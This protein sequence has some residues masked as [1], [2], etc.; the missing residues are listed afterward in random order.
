MTTTLKRHRTSGNVDKVT[1]TPD[2]ILFKEIP[3]IF[4]MEK[5][6]LGSILSV[7]L[8]MKGVRAG[9]L[10]LSFKSQDIIEAFFANNQRMHPVNYRIYPERPPFQNMFKIFI[11]TNN[12]PDDL[13]TP[14]GNSNHIALGRFLGYLCPR[15]LN[16]PAAD[17]K[18][19]TNY[20]INLYMDS[21]EKGKTQKTQKLNKTKKASTNSKISKYIIYNFV[22]INDDTNTVEIQ[23]QLS[24]NCTK[25]NKYCRPKFPN[26]LPGLRVDFE[27]E[28]FNY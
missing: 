1:L 26:L 8:A 9:A 18:Q 16:D 6:D 14:K 28:Q 17:K 4:N 5:T 22:C 24:A 12:V 23:K 10:A 15:N 19:K 3:K 11:S 13:I 25:I 27:S 7:Y 21:S 20:S 2:E